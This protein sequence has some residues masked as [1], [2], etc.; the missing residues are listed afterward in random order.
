MQCEWTMA[1]QGGGSQVD[2][3]GM[4]E[5]DGEEEEKK[6]KK[7]RGGPVRGTWMSMSWHQG[8]DR[9]CPALLTASYK[10]RAT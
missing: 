6:K 9:K 3:D 10:N 4:K 8:P 2:K 5:E 7:R 1:D